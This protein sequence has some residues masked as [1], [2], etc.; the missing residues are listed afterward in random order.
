MKTNK[1][2][3]FLAGTSFIANFGVKTETKNTEKTKFST[4]SP[5]VELKNK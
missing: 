5:I 1:Y 3:V 4:P 2:F